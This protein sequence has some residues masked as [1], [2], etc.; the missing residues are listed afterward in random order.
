MEMIRDSKLIVCILPQGRGLG[1]VERLSLEMGIHSSNV[2][3][4][5]GRGA[6]PIGNIGVWDEIDTLAIVVPA[7]RADEIF[8]YIYHAAELDRPRGGIMYQHAV[9]PATQFTMPDI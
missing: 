8:S 4:G 1:L 3:T 5:R 9:G 2:S 6:G 7:E